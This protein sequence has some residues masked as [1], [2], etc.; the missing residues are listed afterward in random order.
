MRF[1]IFRNPGKPCLIKYF[2]WLL[3]VIKGKGLA[4]GT[5]C[6]RPDHKGHIG[7]PKSTVPF[8]K[9]LART[10]VSSSFDT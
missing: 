3:Q 5:F 10:L 1:I 9:G 2:K 7:S 8:G 4:K 6:F